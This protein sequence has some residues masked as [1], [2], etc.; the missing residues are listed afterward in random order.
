[1]D[2]YRPNLLDYHKMRPDRA[3]ENLRFIFSVIH[4]SLR[5]PADAI[6]NPEH[7]VRGA[8]DKSSPEASTAP[9]VT[10]IVGEKTHP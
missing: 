4:R 5:V 6:P 7:I 1:M 3:I 2:K 10:Y 9:I 8:T